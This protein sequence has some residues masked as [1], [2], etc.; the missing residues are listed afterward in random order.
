MYIC[1]YVYTYIYIY[2]RMY[3][4]TYVYIYIYI[5]I[6]GSRKFPESLPEEKSAT[7]LRTLNRAYRTRR[8]YGM[9][10]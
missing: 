7:I 9:V 5:Y 4:C 6:L 10:L 3:I 8:V 1:T 2:T